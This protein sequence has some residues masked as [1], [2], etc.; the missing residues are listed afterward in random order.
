MMD[1]V[2]IIRNE[3]ANREHSYAVIVDEDAPL[4][5]ADINTAAEWL[6]ARVSEGMQ[7]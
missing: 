6:K 7:A 4:Y 5:F 3:A 2:L 1:R